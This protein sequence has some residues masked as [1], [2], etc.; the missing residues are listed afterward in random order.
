LCRSPVV[1]HRQA[2]AQGSAGALSFA[3]QS[4]TVSEGG[5]AAITLTRTGGTTGTVAAKIAIS[6]VTTSPNDYS[7][8]VPG[9]IDPP[10]TLGPMPNNAVNDLAIQS[11]GKILFTGMRGP[12]GEG[13]GRLNADGT[14]DSSFNPTI[15]VAEGRALGLQPDLKIVLIGHVQL[16]ASDPVLGIVRLNSDGSVDSSFSVGS[17]FGDF[18]SNALAI[19]PDGKMIVGG[20]FPSYNGVARPNIVRINSNGT[21]DSGFATG[22]GPNSRVEKVVLQPDGKIII[23]GG[24]TT[25]D[26]VARK[27]LARLNADGSL[28]STFVPDAATV[29]LALFEMALQPDGN[30]SWADLF[31][32]SPSP[33]STLSS[34]DAVERRR[35]L[36]L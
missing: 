11:D 2:R 3:Q 15:S 30:C 5:T 28:D 14:L 34:V 7:A 27:N 29:D 12:T 6:D 24:F 26:G 25:Y 18:S 35:L 4:Y 33:M 17:G 9:K 21:I 16:T 20:N 22:A 1:A 8:P 10:F 13:L 19:Q 32:G 23:G 31:C 36:S